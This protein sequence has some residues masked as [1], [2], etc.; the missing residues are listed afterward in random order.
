MNEQLMMGRLTFVHLLY[1]GLILRPRGRDDPS[2]QLALGTVEVD[3]ERRRLV[4]LCPS[5]NHH[6]CSHVSSQDIYAMEKT[7]LLSLP[8]NYTPS[9]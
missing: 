5:N 3:R 9:L 7:I 4:D 6:W 2:V 8:Q 1:D